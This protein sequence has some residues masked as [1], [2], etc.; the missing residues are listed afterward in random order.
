MEYGIQGT[1]EWGT[2]LHVAA[3]EFSPG[4]DLERHIV[5]TQAA[6]LHLEVVA[7]CVGDNMRINRSYHF[8]Q[9]PQVPEVQASPLKR[10]G[11]IVW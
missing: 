11:A 2:D 3:D 9:S 7:V 1:G 8:D 4:G 5:M 10:Q 6:K